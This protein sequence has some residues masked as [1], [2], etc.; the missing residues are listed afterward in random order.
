MEI[1]EAVLK[2]KGARK[3]SEIPNEILMY[4]QNGQIESVNLIEWQAVNHQSLLRSILPSFKL[5]ENLTFVLS[6]MEKE[7]AETGMKAIRTA[8]Q[9]LDTVLEN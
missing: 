3:T 4:L 9:L 2:R 5:E 6:E 7:N 1:S 8:S